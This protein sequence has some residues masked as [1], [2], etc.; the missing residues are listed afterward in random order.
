MKYED[1]GCVKSLVKEATATM[2]GVFVAATSETVIV[3]EPPLVK[4]ANIDI[5]IEFTF[6]IVRIATTSHHW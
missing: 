1:Y 2:V 6:E 3:G 5:L 4:K